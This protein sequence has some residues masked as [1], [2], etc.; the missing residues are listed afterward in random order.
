M[1]SARLTALREVP[2]R[3]RFRLRS[4]VGGTRTHISGI[5]SSLPLPLGYY[6]LQLHTLTFERLGPVAGD[7]Q[8]EAIAGKPARSSAWSMLPVSLG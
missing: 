3:G 1:R 2:Q 5:L 6:P 8:A 7:H 4:E